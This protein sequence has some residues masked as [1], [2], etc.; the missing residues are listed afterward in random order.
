[1]TD[2][3]LFDSDELFAL[4]EYEFKNDKLD[5]ALLK[6]KVLIEKEEFPVNTLSLL[7]RIYSIL[8]LNMRA[9]KSLEAYIE[10]VP[11]AVPEHF[12]LGLIL[13]N[14]DDIEGAK[15]VWDDVIK[16]APSFPPALYHLAL[17]YIDNGNDLRATELLENIIK[18]AQEGDEH[19]QLANELLSKISS[20]H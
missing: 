15:K 12:H 16:K 3:S 5:Q 18:N 11:E 8:G 9:K 20:T 4:A 6:L 1:M 10:H 2:I 19:I 17:Y 14:Q 7:G 13:R